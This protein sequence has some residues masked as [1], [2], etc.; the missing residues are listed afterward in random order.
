MPPVL[1]LTKGPRRGW[2]WPAAIAVALT[3]VLALSGC[4]LQED[5]DLDRGR[6]LFTARCGTCHTLAEAGT[7]AEI[8][9]DL[10]AAFAEARARGMDSDTIEGVVQSQIAN[11]RPASPQ[12][13]SVY[14]PADLVTGEDAEAVAAYVGSVAGVPDI[15]PPQVPGPPGAQVFADNGCGGCHTLEAAGSGGTVGPNLDDSLPRQSARQIEQS[16]VDPSAQ[17][18]QGFSDLMPPTYGT[19]IPSQ[20]LAALV[21]YLMQCAGNGD[22]PTCTGEQ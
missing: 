16:I 15:M 9:P 13:S 2:A 1:G 14:M 10:D 17:I 20:D 18:V 7:T 12:N 3:G 21:K 22:D 4:D 8:G 19:S 6:E 5:A 11:P